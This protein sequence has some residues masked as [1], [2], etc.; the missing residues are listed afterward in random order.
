MLDLFVRCFLSFL[1]FLVI[2]CIL[3]VKEMWPSAFCRCR[4][5]LRWGRCWTCCH[6]P[7]GKGN[8]EGQ[9]NESLVAE[10]DLMCWLASTK[11]C[12]SLPFL[13]TATQNRIIS[14]YNPIIIQ[15]PQDCQV[16]D[17][18]LSRLFS[19]I[20]CCCYFGL[21]HATPSTSPL[22]RGHTKSLSA[23]FLRLCSLNNII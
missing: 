11:T 20:C 23:P 16:Q 5:R 8:R 1:D 4:W 19:C 2:A 15:V 3:C 21:R 6:S 12:Q 14:E 13:S 17:G 10:R 9:S 22:P 18:P 7:R